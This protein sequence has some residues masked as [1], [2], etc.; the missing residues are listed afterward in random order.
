MR[1][2]FG[3]AM[4]GSMLPNALFLNL[5]AALALPI[6]HAAETAQA[7]PTKPIRLVLP[8]A[9]G[10][11]TDVSAVFLGQKILQSWGVNLLMVN[12]PGANTVIGTELV[13]KAPAD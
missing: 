11:A 10:G 4:M 12:Q 1:V 13:T 8:Q 3:K 5:L 7:Y 6:A 2:L 9:P